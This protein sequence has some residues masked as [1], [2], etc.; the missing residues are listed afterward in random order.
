M[1]HKVVLLLT[2]L[3]KLKVRF[4][5][6]DMRPSSIL[7]LCRFNGPEN[8]KIL[9]IIHEDVCAHAAATIAPQIQLI[10]Q[11]FARY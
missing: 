7:L 10:L 4:H 2:V 8:K 1:S 5:T 11:Q 6:D 9:Y 3:N